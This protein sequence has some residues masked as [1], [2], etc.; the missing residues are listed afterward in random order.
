[1]KQEALTVLS[2]YG[3]SFRLAGALLSRDH[4]TSAAQLYAFCR[5]I[6]NLADDATD[7]ESARAELQA[8][9]LAVLGS[10]TN[11]RLAAQFLTLTQHCHASQ[12]VAAQLIDTVLS[13]LEPVRIAD[14]MGLIRYAYG[15]A[16][17]VGLM[18]CSVLGV[19]ERAAQPYAID[20]GIAMQLTNI[21]RDVV[22]DA[23]INRIYLP[24][25]WLPPGLMPAQIQDHPEAVFAAVQRLLALADQ[26]YESGVQGLCFLP[27][28]ARFAILAAKQL[29]QAIGQH[30]LQLGP[31]YLTTGRYVVPTWQRGILLVKAMVSGFAISRRATA[32]N[33]SLHYA[34]TGMP[35]ANL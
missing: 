29:Y 14:E 27:Y 22:E 12:Q 15:A 33:A 7:T 34:L 18:M 23:A 10:D 19:T 20:L 24:A 4:L 25:T 1:M 2:R 11:H 5:E 3:R 6:D 26:Y 8:V 17:T 31:H 32:H 16:G 21:A 13:D 28:R 35:E 30:I 9:R